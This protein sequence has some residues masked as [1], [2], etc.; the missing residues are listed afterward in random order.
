MCATCSFAELDAETEPC[1]SCSFHTEDEL[2]SKAEV[3][4][5]VLPVIKDYCSDEV[6]NDICDLINRI[7]GYKKVR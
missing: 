4:N 7:K 1:R 5:V 6:V 3:F 2:I